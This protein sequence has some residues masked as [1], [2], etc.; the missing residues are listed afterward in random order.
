MLTLTLM[1]NNQKKNIN[2]FYVISHD[3]GHC[4]KLGL[5]L[6]AHAENTLS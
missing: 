4:M 6:C 5:N 1:A 2:T 3:L